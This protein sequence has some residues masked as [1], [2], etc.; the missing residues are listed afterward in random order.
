VND[1]FFLKILQL[2]GGDLQLLE[3]MLCGKIH[4]CSLSANSLSSHTSAPKLAVNA[5]NMKISATFCVKNSSSSSGYNQLRQQVFYVNQMVVEYFLG[6]V[7]Q[8]KQLR[9]PDGIVDILTVFS[10]GENIAVA[11]DS[12]LLGKIA[13]FNIQTR[14][15]IIYANLAFAEFVQDSDTQRVC[16]GFEE[17]SFE[18]ADFTHEYS[19]ILIGG[20]QQ[21]RRIKVRMKHAGTCPVGFPQFVRSR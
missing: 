6:Y 20:W 21:Q 19:H 13:L 17:F 2:S 11:E 9:I 10:S 14:A 4:H 12:Q 8:V 7:E 16:K 18:L 15:K 3:Q 5:A 1:S